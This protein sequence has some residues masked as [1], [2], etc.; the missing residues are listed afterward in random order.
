MAPRLSS[1]LIL[2]TLLVST[3]SL[4]KVLAE[5]K[6]KNGFFWLKT[7]Q[8]NGKVVYQC[9]ATANSKFQ[10]NEKCESARAVKPK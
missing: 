3:P 2:L 4:A 1:L 5:G 9:R 10:S 8:S 6:P 7:E